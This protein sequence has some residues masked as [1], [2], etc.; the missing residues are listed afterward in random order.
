[1]SAIRYRYRSHAGYGGYA[2]KARQNRD[3]SRA[4]RFDMESML[5]EYAEPQLARMEEREIPIRRRSEFLP[6]AGVVGSEVGY[7][8][9]DRQMD[10]PLSPQ[11]ARSA[12]DSGC[13]DEVLSQLNI[14]EENAFGVGQDAAAVPVIECNAQAVAGE[15]LPVPTNRRTRSR[16][17]I[18]QIRF[19]R[20][21]FSGVP[22]AGLLYG[23]MIGGAAA[24]AVLLVLRLAIL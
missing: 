1:M 8:F 6:S 20:T 11:Q 10:L 22:G 7:D 5:E 24:A 17:P 3:R 9:A 16:S 2:G 18:P 15:A 4:A 19:D 12:D 23:C 14:V 21:V 13:G